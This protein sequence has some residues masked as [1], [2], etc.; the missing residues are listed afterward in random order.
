MLYLHVLA[1]TNKKAQLV[2]T[3][4]KRQ[5]VFTAL[6]SIDNGISTRAGCGKKFSF[7][8]KAQGVGSRLRLVGELLNAQFHQNKQKK[9]LIVF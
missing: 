3:S 6:N 1:A 8:C 4:Q 7:R 5:F 2:Q 9:R